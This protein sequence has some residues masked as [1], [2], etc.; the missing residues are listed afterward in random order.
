MGLDP[1]IGTNLS[2]IMSAVMFVGKIGNGFI[3]DYLG[4]YNMVLICG[5][6]AGIVHLAVW[7]T[8]TTDASVWAFAVLY[9][10]FGGGYIAM[11]TAVIA[12]VVGVDQIEPATGWSFFAWFFGGLFGQPISSAIINRTEEPDYRGAIIFSGVLFLFGACLAL[13]LRVMRGGWKIFVKV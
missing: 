7:L 11:I 12:Q 5:A 4:R 3:S 6:M 8:A 13:T 1:W 9:G 10:W 2:A